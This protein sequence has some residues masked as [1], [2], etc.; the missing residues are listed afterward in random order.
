VLLAICG[1][2]TTVAT[3]QSSRG[4]PYD[5][6]IFALSP[7]LVFHA[8]SNWDL[9]AMAFTS[10]ALWAWARNRPV[11]AGALVGLGTAA[12]LYPVFLLVAVWILAVRTRRYG[13][14][15]WATASAVLT[16]C[17]VNVPVAL[18]YHRGWWEFYKFSFQRPTERSTLWAMFKTLLNGSVAV[19]DAP[20]WV[21]PSIAVALASIAAILGVIV[22]GLAAPVRPRLAQLAF[23]C[24]LAFLISTK[25]WSPQYSLWLVPLIALARPRWRLTL[26][27]QFTE[28]AV[29]MATLTLLLGFESPA[30]SISYGWLMLLL[31][32]RDALLLG[33]AALV[34]R[35]MWRPWLDV[36]RA[37]GADDPGGG[38]FDHA[39]DFWARQPRGADIEFVGDDEPEHHI[40]SRR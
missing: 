23:L 39:P 21:P 13:E 4:R 3:A 33:I 16:W 32:V 28:I 24:V 15:R 31:I 9:L 2:V 19:Q 26:V 5:A 25:V 8:F 7:L 30:H 22:L 36:V 18:A 29:W 37:D 1:L 34:V 11:L 38:V 6:A 40:A 35:D 14:A 12:K 27:W 10:C 20:Y 17:A